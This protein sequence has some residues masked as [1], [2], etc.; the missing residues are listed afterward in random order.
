VR[1]VVVGELE[2]KDYQAPGLA[3]FAPL[4]VAFTQGGTTIYQR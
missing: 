4:T 1:Y 2:R 3:K